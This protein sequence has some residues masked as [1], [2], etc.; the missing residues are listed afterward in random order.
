M[1]NGSVFE[2]FEE[3]ES[4]TAGPGQFT[5]G[6]ELV[7]AQM[8]APWCGNRIEHRFEH[9]GMHFGDNESTL[10]RPI[11]LIDHPECCLG[12]GG[13]FTL[14]QRLL[15]EFVRGRLV[16]GE[17]VADPIGTAP[18]I[19]EGQF[20]RRL[21]QRFLTTQPLRHGHIRGQTGQSANDH[22]GLGQRNQ[23]LLHR[24]LGQRLVDRVRRPHIAGRV[25]AVAT[26][27]RRQQI[28][29]RGRTLGCGGLGP[30]GSRRQLEQQGLRLRH[31]PLRPRQQARQ[32]FGLQ[33]L[34]R[35]T[36]HQTKSALNR[37][38][39]R[40]QRMRHPPICGADSRRGVWVE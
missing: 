30:V 20:L 17:D 23:S 38:H 16:R 22:F 2:E 4:L 6:I 11:L 21:D 8:I 13:T 9:V 34:S 18:Q 39:T 40:L 27:V 32:R 35:N 25:G 3:R 28:G 36:R 12:P 37:L 31:N 26:E 24:S 7:L 14:H 29:R 15:F 5:K 33:T 19:F 1:V 10:E